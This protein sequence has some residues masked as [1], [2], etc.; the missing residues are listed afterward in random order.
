MRGSEAPFVAVVLP[1]GLQPDNR[2]FV[3]SSESGSR[4]LLMRCFPA[5]A[6]TLAVLIVLIPNMTLRANDP[7]S[8]KL[9]DEAAMDAIVRPYDRPDA[10]GV[11]VI[12]IKDGKVLYKKGCGL[13]NVEA[14]IP[15]T[16]RTNFRLASLTKQLTAMAILILAERE[17]LS[18]DGRL[19]DFFP[20]F[21]VYGRDITVHHLLSHTSGLPDYAAHIPAL[22]KEQLRDHDV[23]HILKQQKS[24]DFPPGSKFAYSNS[25]YVLL[26]LV[27]E[28]VSGQTFARFLDENIFQPLGMFDTV[29]HEEGISTVKNRAYGYEPVEKDFRRR[30]QSVTSATLGDGGVYSSVEDLYRWDQA[31]YTNKLVSITTLNQMFTPEQFGNRQQSSYGMGWFIDT[32]GGFRQ[33]SHGGTTVGFRNQILRLPDEKFTVVVLMN[34]S[35]GDPQAIANRIVQ[36]YFDTTASA[37]GG[38]GPGY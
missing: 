18:L 33:V 26:G 36:H 5:L 1:P 6:L 21:P 12:V 27:V 35:D 24:G 4:S 29:A 25:G 31:L 23:L 17:K 19:I 28:K 20:D 10:P 16:T 15:N 2:P 13:A 30:D 34:R 8:S 9:K 38:I 3:A 14:R 22:Q 37:K 7:N 11:S 32:A